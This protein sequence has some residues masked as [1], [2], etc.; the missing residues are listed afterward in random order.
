M[1]KILTTILIL[2]AFDACCAQAAVPGGSNIALS[3][4]PAPSCSKPET[5]PQPTGKPADNKDKAA[6]DAFNVKVAAYNAKVAVF[7]T[8]MHAFNDCMK[9]YV[10]NANNDIQRIKQAVDASAATTH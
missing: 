5:I 4:Y 7:N 3:E 1:R 9:T 8:A 10:D 6:V 2:S